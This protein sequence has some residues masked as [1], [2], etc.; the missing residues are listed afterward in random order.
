MRT[1]TNDGSKYD[2]VTRGRTQRSPIYSDLPRLL[3]V[4]TTATRTATAKII[5]GVPQYRRALTEAMEF[6]HTPR[7]KI[8]EDWSDNVEFKRTIRI[9][10]RLAAP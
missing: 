1:H 5:G 6:K 4:I 10:V 8:N 9:E 7:E 3:L 2:A